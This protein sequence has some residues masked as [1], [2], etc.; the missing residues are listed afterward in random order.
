MATTSDLQVMLDKLRVARYSGVRSLTHAGTTT[1][2]KSDQEMAAA[3]AALVQQ[4]AAATD[5]RSGGV[6]LA[7]FDAD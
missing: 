2:Y 4:I 7:V 1:E 5:G 3:E 6:S